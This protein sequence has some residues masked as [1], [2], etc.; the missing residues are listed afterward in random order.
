M[1]ELIGALS[2]PP[3]IN[4]RKLDHILTQVTEEERV[5][6]VKALAE[7]AVWSADSLARTLT[8]LNYKVSSSS[9]KRYRREVLGL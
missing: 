2:N 9:V 1:T 5:A 4:P 7:P 6:L 8:G 3:K